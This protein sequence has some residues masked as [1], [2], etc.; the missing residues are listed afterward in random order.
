MKSQIFITH[1]VS[2]LKCFKFEII[3]NFDI[4]QVALTSKS[5]ALILLST[6]K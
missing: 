2:Y 6:I 1:T 5:Q 4:F 3:S